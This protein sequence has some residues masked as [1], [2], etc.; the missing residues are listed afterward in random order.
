MRTGAFKFLLGG[1]AATRCRRRAA[2]SYSSHGDT[3]AH[4]RF[5]QKGLGEGGAIAQPA[6][7]A[8][9]VNDALKGGGEAFSSHRTT[10]SRAEATICVARLVARFSQSDGD[11]N[12][13]LWGT[14]RNPKQTPAHAAS[15]QNW[16][17]TSGLG[18]LR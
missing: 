9:A 11:H 5:E 10:P 13:L 17:A 6:A 8:N 1:L 3:V 12:I 15:F 2:S 16:A 18:R 14:A 4:T 7:I